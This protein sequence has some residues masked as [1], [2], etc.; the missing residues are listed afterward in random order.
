MN[1]VT[2]EN[3]ALYNGD[4]CEIIKGIPDECVGLTVFS[5]PFAELY[6][7]S[8]ST[9]DMGNCKSYDQ[10]FNHFTFLV[11]EI[12]R[13]TMPGR[14]CAVHCIDIPAMKERDGYIG[15]KDFPG[16]IIRAF[17]NAGFIYHSRHCIWKDPLT[18]ATRTKALGLMHKQL[19]KD[20]TKC[21]S[22]LP[23]Y[24]LAFRKDGENT[25]RVDHPEGL[26][27]YH[28]ENKIEGSGV[29][30]S[31]NIWRAYASPVWMDIRQGN[32]LNKNPAR[33]EN[34]A[35][36][37]CPLQLDVIER[38]VALW[39]KDGDTVFTPFGGIGSEAYVAVRNNRKAILI[40]LK[41]EYFDC[42][43]KNVMVADEEKNNHCG[44]LF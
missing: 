42:A 44:T 34:D 29:K 35:K 24:L 17:T 30:R 19:C 36:H 23:D 38:A 2:K 7:Y 22:G 12:H 39:S 33:G 13:I 1:Q 10:F 28:G 8:D 15:L 25:I 27:E 20:S 18:E 41:E 31:H 14:I 32:T 16:D 43:V 37:I 40:E 4:C 6:A 5:P 9:R 26:T 21:R 3:Y 11:N